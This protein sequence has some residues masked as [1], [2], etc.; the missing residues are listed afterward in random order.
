LLLRG[1]KQMRARAVLSGGD[2]YD[3]G[4]MTDPRWCRLRSTKLL[5]FRLIAEA[6]VKS[7]MQNMSSVSR[8]SR[9]TSK[10]NAAPASVCLHFC[11]NDLEFELISMKILFS[12]GI[13]KVILWEKCWQA[14]LCLSKNRL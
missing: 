11:K 14:W 4:D 6:K 2:G 8:V 3:C 1:K 9:K 7:N 12:P 13:L 10:G 5:P